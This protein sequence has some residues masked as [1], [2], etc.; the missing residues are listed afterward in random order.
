MWDDMYYTLD[1]A[2]HVQ[3]YDVCLRWYLQEHVKW[4]AV[5]YSNVY[6]NYLHSRLLGYGLGEV[7]VE[8]EASSHD[9]PSILP[10]PECLH[11]HQ[12]VD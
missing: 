7:A 4:A 6:A 2:G 11:V 10:Q 5:G 3:L 12:L 8:D 9:L 1:L